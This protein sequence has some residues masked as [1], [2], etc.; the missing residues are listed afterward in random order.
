VFQQDAILFKNNFRIKLEP[1]K[2]RRIG[3][4]GKKKKKRETENLFVIFNFSISKHHHYLVLSDCM[5]SDS[6]LGREVP[7]FLSAAHHCPD[8]LLFGL[9]F[10]CSKFHPAKAINFGYKRFLFAHG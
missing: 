8:L 3:R 2:R 9:I 6:K 5:L 1:K 4:N 10:K 7:K